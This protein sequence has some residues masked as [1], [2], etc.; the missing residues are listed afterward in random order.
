[1]KTSRR[2]CVLF[3]FAFLCGWHSPGA[4]SVE[5]TDE[6]FTSWGPLPE[7]LAPVLKA[8]SE[9]YARRALKFTCLERVREASYS[10]EEAGR[11]KSRE[12]NLLMISDPS[13]P[14]GFRGLRSKPD[15]ST[16]REEHIDLPFPEPFLWSQLFR[17]H[18]RSTLRF[19][20]GEWHTTPWKLALPVTWASSAPVFD[21]K[22]LVEW[23][24]TA[25]IEYLTGNLVRIVAAP[26]MQEERIR[27]EWQR[28]QT[29][30]RFIGISF[31]PPPLGLELE[32]E[33]GFEHEGFSYPTRLELRTF[34]QIHRDERVTVS[35]RVVEY[36][37]YRFFGTQVKDVIPPLVFQPPTFPMAEPR[38]GG[39]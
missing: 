24:G 7:A 17:D 2:S 6:A 22:R 23:S 25:E 38:A 31:A 33:F 10:G 29:A 15:S 8:K 18:I 19:Q 35:R 1:M 26:S 13:V 28:A 14:E 21:Q 36:S 4:Q 30:F 32:I 11:E 9:G 12:Y 37:D 27:M 3:L 5:G 20:I 39:G 16:G 34:R